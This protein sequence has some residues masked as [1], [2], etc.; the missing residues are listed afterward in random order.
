MK[1]TCPP[2]PLY[3]LGPIESAHTWPVTSISMAELM[4]TMRSFW[5]IRMGSFT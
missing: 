5:A 2:T 1:S 3:S 4:A